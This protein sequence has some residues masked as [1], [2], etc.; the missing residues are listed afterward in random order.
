MKKVIIGLA[1]CAYSVSEGM[2]VP[3]N[4]S[5]VA[6]RESPVATEIA[7]SNQESVVSC[8]EEQ[9]QPEVN[10][11][12]VSNLRA[13]LVHNIMSVM[14]RDCF[15]E[16]EQVEARGDWYKKEYPLQK[17]LVQYEHD[18]SQGFSM[19]VLELYATI[20][21]IEFSDKSGRVVFRSDFCD[22]DTKIPHQVRETGDFQ[23][24]DAN[25]QAK[26]LTEIFIHTEDG[27][28]VIEEGKVRDGST[29]VAYVRTNTPARTVTVGSPQ[30]R[31]GDSEYNYL[32]TETFEEWRRPDGTIF[33]KKTEGVQKIAKPKPPAPVQAA[34]QQVVNQPEPPRHRGGFFRRAF[35]W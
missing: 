12:K 14:V 30:A 10:F 32:S 25:L 4:G 23:M 8:R 1:L 24:D 18:F 21:D 26:P 29:V 15:K 34:P 35:G 27:D 9:S 28:Q 33:V 31:A 6:R 2:L 13:D 11:R 20:D 16:G 17:T 3:F 7:S 22:E 5:Q 19:P